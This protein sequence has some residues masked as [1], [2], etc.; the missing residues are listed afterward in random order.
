MWECSGTRGHVN[1]EIQG[2][3]EWL[4]ENLYAGGERDQKLKSAFF[5]PM[6]LMQLAAALQTKA[7]WK[8]K[9][10]ADGR[11]ALRTAFLR[12]VVD[13]SQRQWTIYCRA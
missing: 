10:R 2:L 11:G 13:A 9:L 7:M 5:D 12:K 1:M 3:R 4:E 8:E 6:Q